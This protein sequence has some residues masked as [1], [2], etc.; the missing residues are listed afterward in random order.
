MR[1]GSTRRWRNLVAQ[2]I[3]EE[4]GIC[5]LCGRPGADS[6]DH[7]IPVKYRPDLELV[8]QN[9][10]ACH[11]RCNSQRGTKPVPLTGPLSTSRAW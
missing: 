8:R 5:H 9:V 1:R 6:G 3:A 7:L 2:V 11:R 10:R 4:G